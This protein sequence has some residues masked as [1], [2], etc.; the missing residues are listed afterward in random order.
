VSQEEGCREEEWAFLRQLALALPVVARVVLDQVA[1]V[2]SE[3]I[4]MQTQPA[5]IRCDQSMLISIAER[6]IR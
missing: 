2:P 4:V 6:R 1:R 3:M 5:W